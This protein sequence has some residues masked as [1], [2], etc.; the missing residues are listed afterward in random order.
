LIGLRDLEIAKIFGIS[1]S[2]HYENRARINEE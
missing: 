2:R 1:K